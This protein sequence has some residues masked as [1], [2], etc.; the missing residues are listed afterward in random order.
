[1]KENHLRLI[2][3]IVGHLAISVI[4]VISVESLKREWGVSKTKLYDLIEVMERICLI[5]VVKRKA[6]VAKT[7]LR[8]AR[9]FFYDPSTYYVL[10][11]NTANVQEAFVACA[12]EE[13][14][15]EIYASDDEKT[16]GLVVNGVTLEVGGKSKKLKG[17]DFVVRDGLDVPLSGVIPM[18]L[19]GMMY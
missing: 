2:Q 4:P 16:C 7:H 10:N 5:R 9:L 14:S 18:W 15:R 12:F 11:G 17:A 3:A 8:G 13:A 1:M 6:T 19:L